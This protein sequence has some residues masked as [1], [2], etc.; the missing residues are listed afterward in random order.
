MESNCKEAIE[1]VDL[2]HVYDVA[3]ILGV[4]QNTLAVWRSAGR[5][6]PYIK[7]CGFIRYSRADLDEWL[8]SSTVVPTP[9]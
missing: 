1:G 7:V 9:K 4:R 3:R 5:G 8:K 2:L 6:P